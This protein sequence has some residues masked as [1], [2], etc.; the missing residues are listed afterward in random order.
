MT[1][2]KL[3][4]WY[5]DQSIFIT[6]AT[7]FMGKILVEKLLRSCPSAKIYVLIRAK[8]GKTAQQR[9]NDFLDC[10]VSYEIE[11][12]L[13]LSVKGGKDLKEYFY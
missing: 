6:G 3:V 10:P 4:Q 2:S 11:I 12:I 8:K 1:E 13:P 7:G 5:E 9:L